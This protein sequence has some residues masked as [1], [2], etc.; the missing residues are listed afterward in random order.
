MGK[1]Q[2]STK[3]IA[4][5]KND[6][7]AFVQAVDF[8]L[9]NVADNLKKDLNAMLQGDG[10]GALC[11]QVGAV[12]GQTITVDNPLPLRPNMVVNAWT[13]R[14]GGTQ[15]NADATISD[16][17]YDT[18]VVTL[19]GT[20]TAFA[21]A[22]YIFKSTGRGVNIMGLLGIVDDATYVT[23]L[24]NLSRSTYSFWKS[25]IVANGGVKRDLSQVLLQAAE[26]KP[27]IRAGGKIGSFFSNLGQRQNYV[28]LVTA[29][30]RYINTM[31]F[32]AGYEALEYNGKPWF[33]D[34]DAIKNA[35]YALDESVFRFAML[36]EIDWMDQDGAILARDSNTLSYTAT[37]Q[38][39]MEL[40]TYQP[41][42]S[43]VIR[44]LNEPAGY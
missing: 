43:S 33:V 23:T 31:K 16:V 25:P 34:R 13:A 4:A 38:G 29:D 20:I 30:R 42:R 19:V 6:R 22:D 27:Y 32:D 41:N 10:S 12:S 28:Q 21:D 39:H 36:E 3:V 17:N 8:K 40:I 1:F 14:S 11:Q 7:G 35:I 37:L 18:K 15:H 5:T 9:R 26:D 24:Q 2:V 44:D